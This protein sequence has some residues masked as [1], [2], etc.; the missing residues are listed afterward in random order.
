MDTKQTRNN[1][2]SNHNNL[3][4][5]KSNYQANNILHPNKIAQYKIEESLY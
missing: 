4:N 2:K 5:P 3:P 1:S